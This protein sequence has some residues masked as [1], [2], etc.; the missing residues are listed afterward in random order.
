MR[1]AVFLFVLL[2]AGCEPLRPAGATLFIGDSIT[3]NWATDELVVGAI[4][5]GVA[6][7]GS[8]QMYKR[9]LPQMQR[10]RPGLVH[11]LAGTND[12]LHVEKLRT[13]G[14]VLAMGIHARKNGAVTV[15]I[16]TIPP[17]D[18]RR[19][20]L[21]ADDVTL[22]NQLLKFFAYLCGFKVAD[23]NAAMTGP[24]GKIKPDLFTDGIHPNKQGYVVMR[25]VFDDAMGSV[26]KL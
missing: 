11:I 15:I 10:Q 19:V 18:Q 26:S 9:A 13:V 12:R 23:Y 17:I 21:N 2:L 20:M 25:A 7:E 4:N 3:K 5:A 14:K 8:H 22:Y 24:D 1:Y 6:G 16:G